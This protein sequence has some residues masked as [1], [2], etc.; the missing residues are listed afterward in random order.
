MSDEDKGGCHPCALNTNVVAGKCEFCSPDKYRLRGPDIDCQPRLPCVAA[1]FVTTY[2]DLNTLRCDAFHSPVASHVV[3][4]EPMQ[5]QICLGS[6]PAPTNSTA[7]I[8]CPFGTVLKGGVCAPCDA[9]TYAKL[10]VCVGVDKGYAA[11]PEAD[12]FHPNDVLNGLPVTW[13]SNCH[14]E[15]CST[16]R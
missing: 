6:A 4:Y 7:C 1:D 16:N 10:G 2:L 12:F 5:P 11:I 13:T 9:G 15:D 3:T 8:P 14:G